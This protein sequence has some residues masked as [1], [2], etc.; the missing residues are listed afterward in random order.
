MKSILKFSSIFFLAHMLLWSPLQSQVLLG[1]AISGEGSTD[2]SGTAIALSSDGNILAIASERA[3]SAGFTTGHVRVF[4]FQDSMWIQKGMNIDGQAGG[5]RA[6]SSLDISADGTRVA[7][8][9]NGHNVNRGHVRVF[10]WQDSSWVQIGQDIDGASGG[11][12]AGSSLSLSSDGNRLAMGAPWNDD[13]ASNSGQVR[14]FDWDGTNWIQIGTDI[15]GQNAGDQAG[16]SVVLSSDGNRLAIGAI[17][18]DSANIQDV[19][20]VI[21]FEWTGTDWTQLGPSIYG[22]NANDVFGSSI[23][24]SNNGNRLAASAKPTSR[25][26]G[27]YIRIFEWDGTNW[28]QV[29]ADILAETNGDGFGEAID[30]SED[31][32]RIAGGAPENSQNIS[33]AGHVRIFDWDGGQWMQVGVDIEGSSTRADL[34]SA[35]AF[36]ADGNILAVGAPFQNGA[37]GETLVYELDFTSTP[38][39]PYISSFHAFEKLFPNPSTGIVHLQI[40]LNTSAEVQLSLYNL[41]GQVMYSEKKQGLYGKNQ[42]EMNI[43]NLPA[44]IYEVFVTVKNISISRKLEI[45]K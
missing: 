16:A 24:L 39:D 33:G 43:K 22:R 36:S 9:S 6:G 13:V 23:R 14:V 27:G 44:G 42:L 1:S 31:G 3:L 30:L 10:E 26:I 41:F 4:S 8:G 2:A 19:G 5:D 12:R 21:V 34:G 32:N 7:I 17:D 11:S 38:I 15:E 37:S 20:E 18:S 40:N 45:R 28:N 29:G 35:L 25:R